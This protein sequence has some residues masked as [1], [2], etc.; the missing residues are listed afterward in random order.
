MEY[1]ILG[2]FCEN[3]LISKVVPACSVLLLTLN[4][5]LK[6]SYYE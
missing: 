6:K 4:L 3:N 2:S 5:P 1:I